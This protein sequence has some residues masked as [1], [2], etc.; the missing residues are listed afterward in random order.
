MLGG[1]NFSGYNGVLKEMR[2]KYGNYVVLI[3][4]K[5]NMYKDEVVPLR[6]LNSDRPIIVHLQ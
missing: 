2:D 5:S 6:N 4:V 3:Q 1:G